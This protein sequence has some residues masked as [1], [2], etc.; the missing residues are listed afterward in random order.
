MTVPALARHLHLERTTAWRRA[1]AALDLGFLKNLEIREGRPAKLRLGDNV[2]DENGDTFLPSPERLL[3][4]CVQTR[5]E[6][7]PLPPCLLVSCLGVVIVVN[8]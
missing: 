4:R 8:P 5:G 7:P 6:T 1:R 3:R 2:P